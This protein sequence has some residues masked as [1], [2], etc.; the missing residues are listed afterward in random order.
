MKD[1]V[2]A[3][4]EEEEEGEEEEKEEKEE[5]EEEGEEFTHTRSFTLKQQYLFPGKETMS[6]LGKELKYNDI[7]QYFILKEPALDRKINAEQS[8]NKIVF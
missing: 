6:S 5:K 4:E 3:Q 2:E 8:I 7:S 1:E